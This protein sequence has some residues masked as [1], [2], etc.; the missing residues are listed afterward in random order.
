[1]TNEEQ[2]HLDNDPYSTPATY[3]VKVGQTIVTS[4][5]PE[6]TGGFLLR[7]V[8]LDPTL[9]YS[10]QIQNGQRSFAVD[11]NDNIDATDP[12]LEYLEPVLRAGHYLVRVDNRRHALT[13]PLTTGRA[14]LALEGRS[15]DR[16]RLDQILPSGEG[17]AIGPDESVDLTQVGIERFISVEK[18]ALPECDTID[19]TILT[20]IGDWEDSFQKTTPIS[21]VVAAA[22][23]KFPDFDRS[24]P[25][26]IRRTTT[27]E[28]LIPERTLQSYHICDGEK[29]KFLPA[30]DGGGQ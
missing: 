29:L 2:K 17:R 19:I 22:L 16:Y 27:D 9:Y 18:K 20:P 3:K 6:P 11:T 23:E 8:G 5:D 15:P 25:Y 26:E 10:I 1:M 13:T 24:K 12:G 14:L 4:I 30:Q 7:E 21:R 28:V